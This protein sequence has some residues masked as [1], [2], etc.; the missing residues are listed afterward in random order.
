MDKKLNCWEFKKCGRQEG[1]ENAGVLGG[2]PVCS[3]KEADGFNDGVNGGRG[4][5]YIVGSFSPGVIDDVEQ[6]KKADCSNCEFYHLLKRDSR[7]QMRVRVFFDYIRQK[8]ANSA[9]EAYAARHGQ[10]PVPDPEKPPKQANDPAA[11][12]DIN[13]DG[14]HTPEKQL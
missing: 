9:D 5:A 7:I 13:E 14:P 2:C 12:K 3:A 10:S 8:A 4:C 11:E 1:G 6:N